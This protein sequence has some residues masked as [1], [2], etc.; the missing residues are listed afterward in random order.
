MECFLVK[1][2]GGTSLN[3][4][5]IPNPMPSTAKENTIWVD[6]DKINNY[7]FSAE[8]PENM[9]EYDVWF[10]VGTSSYVAFSATKKNPIMVYPLYAKQYVSGAWVDKTAKSYHGGVW[11]D[12][13]TFLYQSGNEYTDLTGGWV[14]KEKIG[15]AINGDL[16]TLTKEVSRLKVS[17][18]KPYVNGV[19]RCNNTI[20]VTNFRQMS[21]T[22]S[23]SKAGYM[24]LYVYDSLTPGEAYDPKDLSAIA[25]VIDFTTPTVIDISEVTGKKYIGIG[26][27][28]PASDTAATFY[29]DEVALS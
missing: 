19:V 21:V 3:F 11:V 8:Q 18:P 6:T 17:L 10:S 14:V 15:N 1:N 5:V 25:K 29:I 20:D 13:I 26:C 23:G 4:K 22:F 24:R 27:A 12:W 16:P 2:G 7:Y 9:V 28:I